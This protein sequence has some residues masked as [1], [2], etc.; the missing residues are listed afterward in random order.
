MSPGL[1]PAMLLDSAADARLAA[2]RRLVANVANAVAFQ[3]GWFACVLG[4]AYDVVWLGAGVVAL[5][6]AVQVATAPRPGGEAALAILALALGASFEAALI[7]TGGVIHN[8]APALPPAWMLA[9]WPL[10]AGTLTRS[11]GWL[12]GRWLLAAW[13][14]GIAGPL[15]YWAGARL[16]ALQVGDP[17]IFVAVLA[18]GWAVLTPLLVHYAHR[19]AGASQPRQAVEAGRQAPEGESR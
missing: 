16:G 11:M 19:L 3:A 15:S 14:G 9:L 13:L 5:I 7:A 6:V 12:K 10:F 8:G 4:A 18:T 17:V 2:R 1:A